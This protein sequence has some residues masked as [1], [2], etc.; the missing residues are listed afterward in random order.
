MYT[1]KDDP[2]YLRWGDANQNG[3]LDGLDYGMFGATWGKMDEKFEKQPADPEFDA[4]FDFNNNG[5]IDG[6]DYGTFGA[7]WALPPASP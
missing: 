7:N 6:L 1:V 2:A 3:M 4:R 5:M